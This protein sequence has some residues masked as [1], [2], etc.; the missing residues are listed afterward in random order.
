MLNL[1]TDC[2]VFVTLNGSFAVNATINLGLSF[3]VSRYVEDGVQK[4]AF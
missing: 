2:V 3:D 1:P 4:M